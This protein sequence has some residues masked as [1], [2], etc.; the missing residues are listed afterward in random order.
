MRKCVLETVSTFGGEDHYVTHM[1][2]KGQ[3]VGFSAGLLLA[4]SPQESGLLLQ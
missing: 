1:S 3:I 4:L 2:Q